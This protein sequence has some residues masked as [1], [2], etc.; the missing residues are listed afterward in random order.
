LRSL[1]CIIFQTKESNP[2]QRTASDDLILLF[3]PVI[4]NASGCAS[5]HAALQPLSSDQGSDMSL[6]GCSCSS[7]YL[8]APFP[9]SSVLPAAPSHAA[10]QPLSFDQGSDM[11]LQGCSC[12]SM[13]SDALFSNV[14]CL[15][16]STF[17]CRFAASFI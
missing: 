13:Y 2:T 15:A 5:S 12:S 17:S 7:M 14:L 8:D 10:L 4:I 16:S 1:L 11:S 9:M 6:Q 3:H